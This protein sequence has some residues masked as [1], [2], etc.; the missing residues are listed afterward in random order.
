MDKV[1]YKELSYDIVGAAFEVFRELGYGYKEKFYEDAI[2]K[3]FKKKNLKYK[4]QLQYKVI[5]KEE[6]IGIQQLDFLVEEKIIV[7]L[8]RGDYFSK[9]NIEQ[10]IQYLKTSNLKLAI[11]I[12][13][14][15]QGVKF[16]R[17]LNIK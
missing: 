1:I 10:V 4:R 7:E 16:K 5:Y 2:A 13:I 12:N 3:E 14:T 6:V 11:L 17:I 9:N 15:S 8:K